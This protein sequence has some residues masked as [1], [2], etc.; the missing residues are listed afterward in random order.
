PSHASRAVWDDEDEDAILVL[1][2]SSTVTSRRR[3]DG[4]D[5]K[6]PSTP[7]SNMI[8]TPARRDPLT[9]STGILVSSK[10]SQG[11]AQVAIDR[12][13]RRSGGGSELNLQ[14]STTFVAS[15]SSGHYHRRTSY[16][17]AGDAQLL[18]EVLRDLQ[19]AYCTLPQLPPPPPESTGADP[20]PLSNGCTL[21][22]GDMLRQYVSSSLL[23]DH[24][25]NSSAGE[26][27]LDDYHRGVALRL[28]HHLDN[29]MELEHRALRLMVAQQSQ[30]RK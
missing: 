3:S 6:Y 17:S 24:R 5:S 26:L 8:T 18:V 15:P 27:Q 28:E 4:C 14:L 30:L 23:G 16:T 13:R 12:R 10:V 21:S 25:N 9:T 11:A 1:P 22:L 19:T 29:I 7:S 20:S 2:A